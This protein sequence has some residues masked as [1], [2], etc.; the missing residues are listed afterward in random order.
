MM[1]LGLR[2]KYKKDHGAKLRA[3][4]RKF[5][6][7]EASASA[8]AGMAGIERR[9]IGETRRA[10]MREAGLEARHKREFGR[11]NKVAGD[12]GGFR[13]A[14]LGARAGTKT[15]KKAT[16]LG[17]LTAKETSGLRE[18][19]FKNAQEQMAG[20]AD[21]LTGKMMN[22]ATGQPMTGKTQKAIR[23]R[24]TDEYYDYASEGLG[25]PLGGAQRGL[26]QRPVGRGTVRA[27]GGRTWGLDESMPL[28]Q[29]ITR[30]SAALPVAPSMEQQGRGLEA[31][32]EVGAATEVLPSTMADIAPEEEPELPAGRSDKGAIA[33]RLRAEYKK[34]NPD[35]DLIAALKKQLGAMSR[36]IKGRM[37]SPEGSYVGSPSG[38]RG[39]NANR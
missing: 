3:E 2:E 18:A 26:A 38:L 25:Q 17:G 23:D 36:W 7:Q 14:E 27:E 1:D 32:P 5:K 20:M 12:P 24:L 37:M 6:L 34:E 31:L 8:D 28:G 9:Q 10:G 19:A 16:G 11:P 39:F 13:Y 35:P 21:P 15:G 30:G 29:Q 4:R 22:P 33:E